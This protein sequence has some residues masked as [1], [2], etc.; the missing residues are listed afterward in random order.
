MEME[1]PG[2]AEHGKKKVG[3]GGNTTDQ[4]KRGFLVSFFL[5]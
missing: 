3:I 4:K 2:G 1:M 5:L